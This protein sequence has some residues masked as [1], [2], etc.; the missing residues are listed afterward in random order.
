MSLVPRAQDCTVTAEIFGHQ[1]VPL[2]PD[3]RLTLVPDGPGFRLTWQ[4]LAVDLVWQVIPEA[5]PLP[6][7]GT[8]RLGMRYDA[9]LGPDGSFIMVGRP[10]GIEYGLFATCA[11]APR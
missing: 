5:G 4:E 9:S 6:L 10:G 3:A 11:H 2:P 8:D 7:S 1:P